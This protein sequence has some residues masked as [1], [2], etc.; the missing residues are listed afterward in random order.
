MSSKPRRQKT[1]RGIQD[2]SSRSDCSTPCAVYVRHLASS[3]DEPQNNFSVCPLPKL[4]ERI[5]VL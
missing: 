4:E 1:D 2:G 3:L 5:H